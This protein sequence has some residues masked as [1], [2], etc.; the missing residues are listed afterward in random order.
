MNVARIIE[1]NIDEAEKISL[2]EEYIERLKN[3]ILAYQL[4]DKV[5]V[6]MIQEKVRPVIIKEVK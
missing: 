4:R 6:E 1:S 3:T 5:V 2:I